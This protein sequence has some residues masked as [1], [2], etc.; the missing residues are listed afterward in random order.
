MST[1]PE[2]DRGFKDGI[3]SA[4]TWLHNEAQ[5]M[6]DP[7]AKSLYDLA[8]DH[9]GKTLSSKVERLRRQ[10]GTMHPN[11]IHNPQA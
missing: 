11:P 10:H 8:A 4:I 9:L 5:T 6:N 1:M 3:R 7:R 2:Y